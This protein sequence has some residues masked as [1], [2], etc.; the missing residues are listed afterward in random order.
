MKKFEEYVA[1]V[2]K[3]EDISQLPQKKGFNYTVLFITPDLN[4]AEGIY[5]TLLPAMVLNRETTI[6]ALPRGL[7][8]REESVSIN[9]KGYEI[10]AKEAAVAQHIVFPFVSYD[11][12][13]NIDKL[14]VINPKLKFS[15]YID[16]NYYFTPESYPFANEYNTADKIASIE[17]NISLV[18]QVIV[19]NRALY[20]YLAKE[21]KDKEVIKGKGTQIAHQPLYFSNDFIDKDMAKIANHNKQKRFGFVLNHYHFSDINY[22]RGV[23]KDFIKENA[24]QAQLV[25]VGFDGVHKG[26]NYL[27]ALNIEHH[28]EVPFFQYFEMLNDLAIDCFVIPSSPKPFYA[29]SKNY[30]KYLEFSRLGVPVIAP[31]I[32]PY[33]KIISNNG[34]GILCD[35][36]ETWAFQMKTFL[37]DPAKFEAMQGP[38]YAT[39][40]DHD[41]NDPEAI[42]H[43]L[44]VFEI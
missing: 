19:T 43:L 28:P 40:A 1:R 20:N 27:S 37:D 11:L 29:T 42:K 7:S 21:L 13:D 4:Y 31:N 15:M 5:R 3:A 14:R 35:E 36:K 16:F 10:I 38:A 8:L 44:N 34:N 9:D 17:K 39:S 12:G 25:M 22:I 2:L 33:S 26:K 18:D 32:E 41:I 30:I 24:A 6:R 23:L